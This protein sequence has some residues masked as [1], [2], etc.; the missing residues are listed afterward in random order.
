MKKLSDGALVEAYRKAKLL[1][2]SR[3]FI[4]LLSEELERRNLK[5]DDGD[6]F[7]PFQDTGT[8]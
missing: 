1:G 8:N 5:I 4:W 6:M 7:Y 2:L 3:E